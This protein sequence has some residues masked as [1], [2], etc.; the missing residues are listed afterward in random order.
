MIFLCAANA[1]YVAVTDILST[2]A[3]GNRNITREGASLPPGVDDMAWLET[4]H[5]R[6]RPHSHMGGHHHHAGAGNRLR[7]S[8]LRL[9]QDEE[10]AT[11][12]SFIASLGANA[13]PDNLDPM[14]PLDPQLVVD[15]DTRVEGARAELTALVY[16]TWASYPVVI[17]SK[18]SSIAIP[19]PIVY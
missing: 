6:P 4:I 8:E 14:K 12:V 2:T 13:L 7:L 11:L 15:F 10:L 17:F 1:P 9:H 18:V 16:E 5:R 3:G 19:D